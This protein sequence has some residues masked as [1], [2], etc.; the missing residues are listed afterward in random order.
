[1]EKKR[2]FVNLFKHTVWTFLDYIWKIIIASILWF[3]FSIPIIW[4]FVFFIYSGII[5]AYLYI[6]VGILLFFSP[7]SFGASYYILQIVSQYFTS[8]K[9]ILFNKYSSPSDIKV[10]IFFKGI[11]RFFLPSILTIVINLLISLFLYLNI[12]FYWRVVIPKSFILGLFLTGIILWASLLYLFTL[13]Y[14]IPIIITKR[15]NLF[16]ALYQSFLLVIDNMFYT[17]GVTVF[18]LSMIVI[19]IFSI[20]GFAV[21]FYGIFALIQLFSM[22]II[23]QKYDDTMEYRE[24]KRGMKNLIKPWD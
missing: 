2:Y 14:L 10:K 23:Y 22:L 4:L 20:A 15:V 6:A 18:L 13:N 21:V 9:F 11:K 16:K 12:T 3:L 24:E 5:N 8:D 19:M 17:I 7:I 1:M